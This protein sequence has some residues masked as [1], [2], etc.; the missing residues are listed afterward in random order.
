MDLNK[1]LEGMLTLKASDLYITVGAPILFR[2]DGELRPQ[3]E[4][5]TE[6]DV[7]KLLDS[8]MDPDRRQE[9]RKSRESNFAIVRDCG[10]FRV[11]AFFQR[12]LPGAVIRRIETIIPTFEQLK[13]PLVL[14]DLAIAKRG[15]VLVVGATG[16]GKSTTMA[17]MTG[18]RNSNKTGHILTVEDPIEFV[19]EH[20]RCIV[21]QREVGLD[22]ESYEVALKNSLRQAPDMILIGEIRSRET[23]EYAMTFAETGHLCM[24]TLHAN[25][26]NQAL[27]RILHLVP[28]D[29]KEQFLFDLSMNL[30]GVIGQQ[31]I[32][33]KNGQG[34]HG[35][36]E[37]L[38]NSPRVSDLIRR[39]DLHELKSTMARSNEFGMLTFDQ[40]LY[41]LV[42]QGKISEEDALHSADSANDLRLMLKT[43]RGE[44]FS[45][46]SLANVKIDMD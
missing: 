22:T 37:I 15:L 34:R 27:E 25:N 26:A 45:T 32:R 42:M 17:A 29:Q 46:G 19:H 40:S 21:T 8:A 28:K 2:V 1:F 3:G 35:V 43:Q 9:F 41:K 33:D 16:S 20:K 44:P 24:A 6:H 18:Y 31:L 36:F 11:S 10:R 14:Q 39:G 12:E 5:L 38:L 30:K 13:L 4:K 23:M 7:A